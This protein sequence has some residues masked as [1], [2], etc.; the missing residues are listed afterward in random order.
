MQTISE[1]APL[2]DGI[3]VGLCA[4]IHAERANK[5]TFDCEETITLKGD[6]TRFHTTVEGQ[7]FCGLICD[8]K[9]LVESQIDELAMTR[10]TRKIGKIRKLD[11]MVI[12]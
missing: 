12:T 3:P 9:K 5:E 1:L 10:K 8:L 2:F 4:L 6:R 7:K 11:G